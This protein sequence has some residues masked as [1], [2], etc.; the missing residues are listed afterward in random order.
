MKHIIAILPALI[1]ALGLC[2]NGVGQW[3]LIIGQGN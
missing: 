1:I 2:D 3:L